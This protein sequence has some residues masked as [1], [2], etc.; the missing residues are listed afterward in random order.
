M[1]TYQ[2]LSDNHGWGVIFETEADTL[3]QALKTDYGDYSDG[4]RKAYHHEP[5]TT[6]AARRTS[7][8]PAIR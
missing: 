5:I 3:T 1:A 2:A 8:M 7:A 6:T 4:L